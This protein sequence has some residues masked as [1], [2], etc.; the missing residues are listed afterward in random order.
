MV[1]RKAI[2]MLASRKVLA[3]TFVILLTTAGAAVAAVGVGGATVS[4]DG[5][6]VGTP[7]NDTLTTGNAD[8]IVW[9]L[10]G[11]DN[12]NAGNGNDMIDAGGQCPAADQGQ[13]FPN[14][15]PGSNQCEH[16]DQG[17][18]G[19]ATINAGNG[20]DTIFGGPS[21]D[22]INVGNG[23]YTIT[24]GPGGGNTVNVGLIGGKPAAGASGTVNARNGQPD[25]INCFG[26]N[27]VTVN[28]DQFDTVNR[29][30]HVNRVNV[31]RDRWASSRKRAARA[32]K[33]RAKHHAK[34]KHHTAK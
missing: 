30:A 5:T 32:H 14:G 4:G 22:K 23:T 31:A 6:L 27:T 8:D 1:S 21:G 20:K 28:A 19:S 17:E 18:Q 10:G 34:R 24:L 15:I 11:Q 9:G 16:G 29:C 3:L 25:T 13:D 2:R 7:G 12:I 26:K 33:A